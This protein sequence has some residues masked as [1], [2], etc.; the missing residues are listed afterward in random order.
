[1]LCWLL[2]LTAATAVLAGATVGRAVRPVQALKLAAKQLPYL[3]LSLFFAAGAALIAIFVAA[4]LASGIGPQL[5]PVMF[6]AALAG[7]ALLGAR[8]LF[9]IPAALF[10][11]SAWQITRGRLWPTAGAVLLGGVVIPFIAAALLDTIS[12]PVLPELADAVLLA[13]VVAMQAGLLAHIYIDEYPAADVD[14]RLGALEPEAHPRPLMSLGLLLPALVMT[15]IVVTNPYRLPRVDAGGDG[16]PGGAVTLAWPAGSQPIL[17]STGAIRFCTNPLCTESVLRNGGPTVMHDWGVAGI[18]LSGTVVKASVTGGADNGGPFIHFGQCTRDGDCR[19]EAWIPTRASSDE[20]FTWPELAVSSAPDGAL[21]FALA[22]S[23][24]ADDK[25]R[26]DGKVEFKFIRCA[27]VKC[28]KPQ[29]FPAGRIKAI[30]EQG[31]RSQQRARLRI[32]PDGRPVASFWIGHTIQTVTCDPVTCANPRIT[33]ASAGP[34][35]AL[36]TQHGSTTVWLSNG[37]LHSSEGLFQQLATANFAER[38]QAIAASGTGIYA[39][40]AVKAPKPAGLRLTIGKEPE[41][42]QYF[43]WHCPDLT[44]A[45]PRRIPLDVVQGTPLPVKLAVGQD[46]SALLVREDRTLLIPPSQPFT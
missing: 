39:A 15:A 21:I 41:F 28:V 17:V 35:N 46:G 22:Q 25:P 40:V 23:T 26:T 44:C 7:L 29:R 3:V 6:I 20:P 2:T 45:N 8:L 16:P 38:A 9:A 36:W 12:M 24:Q 13:T 34:G 27:D 14:G 1:V 32:E 30:M 5:G 10:G 4:R 37:G 19:N 11:G 18:G 42:W 33:A 43:V 31:P